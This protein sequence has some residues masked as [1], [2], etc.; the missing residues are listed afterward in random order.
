M[1]T[2]DGI[3]SANTKPM[4]WSSQGIRKLLK[5]QQASFFETFSL[6][7]DLMWVGAEG[8]WSVKYEH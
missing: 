5:W 6:H 1:P 2:L 3:S 7:R 4:P 8:E